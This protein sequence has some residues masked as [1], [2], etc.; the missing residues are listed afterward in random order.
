MPGPYKG[1]LTQRTTQ[2]QHAKPRHQ[3]SDRDQRARDRL[4]NKVSAFQAKIKSPAFIA[5]GAAALQTVYQTFNPDFPVTFHLLMLTT[6]TDTN[7][8]PTLYVIQKDRHC[9]PTSDYYFT[10][11]QPDPIIIPPH[12]GNNSSSTPQQVAAKDPIPQQTD[13]LKPG[14]TRVY[15]SMLAEKQVPVLDLT[16]STITSTADLQTAFHSLNLSPTKKED[17]SHGRKQS[18]TEEE[19]H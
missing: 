19:T 10:N 12:S 15:P 3:P 9:M 4:R 5:L 13:T 7:T 17:P 6:K 11:I 16:N 18:S 2:Q 8:I 14:K 1:F